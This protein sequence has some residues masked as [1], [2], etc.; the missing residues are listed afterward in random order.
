VGAV[1]CASYLRTAI[2][3]RH[4]DQG[5]RPGRGRP[6]EPKRQA[7][8]RP[9]PARGPRVSR[10]G[11]RA[12]SYELQYSTT[13]GHRNT[14]R[15]VWGHGTDADRP[16]AVH[17]SAVVRRPGWMDP[18]RPWFRGRAAAS[19]PLVPPP[20]ID[21]SGCAVASDEE[22]RRPRCDSSCCPGERWRCDAGGWRLGGARVL[23]LA[24][25]SAVL[26]VPRTSRDARTVICRRRQSPAHRE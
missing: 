21:D 6:K 1:A 5:A 25:G 13:A 12:H 20:A 17:Q 18:P 24:P 7:Q 16:L 22:Q 3:E 14:A 8:S 2:Q 10:S 23:R 4:S 15:P 26:T 19:C 11:G 9:N